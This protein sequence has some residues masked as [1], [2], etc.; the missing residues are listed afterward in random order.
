[1]ELGK[2]SMFQL[3]NFTLGCNGTSSDKKG[4]F[5]N[6]SYSHV[7][8]FQVHF[9]HL[10]W[11]WIL[12][13]QTRGGGDILV[14]SFGTMCFIWLFMMEGWGVFKVCL[15]AHFDSISVDQRSRWYFPMFDPYPLKSQSWQ[16]CRHGEGHRPGSGLDPCRYQPGSDNSNIWNR[17]V[18][19]LDYHHT[20]L[21]SLVGWIGTA[22]VKLL[23]RMVAVRWLAVE[24][25]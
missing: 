22:H 19:S 25:L 8:P 9:F 23:S 16:V 20:K 4:E 10:N 6:F 18:Q 14:L 7:L 24:A 17:Q 12:G 15:I 13:A 21:K 3:P 11:I 2:R 1:M 5:L